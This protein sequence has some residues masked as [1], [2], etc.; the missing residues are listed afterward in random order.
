MATEDKM[1]NKDFNEVENE[2]NTYNLKVLIKE[3]H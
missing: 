2:G 1:E 3:K